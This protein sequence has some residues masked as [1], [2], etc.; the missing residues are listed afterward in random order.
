LDRSSEEKDVIIQKY[1][2]AFTRLKSFDD[3]EVCPTVD[4]FIPGVNCDSSFRYILEDERGQKTAARGI[5][6][7]YKCISHVLTF[8]PKFESIFV[9]DERTNREKLASDDLQGEFLF[10][11]LERKSLNAK[12][13]LI[14]IENGKNS[15]IE[16]ILIATEN[17]NL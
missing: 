14:K 4:N 11:V 9:K 13:D 6:N 16:H 7:F 10:R 1:K 15:S 2:A 5:A 12:I 8:N 17:R 3:E